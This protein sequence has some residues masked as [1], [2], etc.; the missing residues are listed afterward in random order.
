MRFPLLCALVPV[1]GL[2][3]Q[4]PSGVTVDEAV[5]QALANNA[6]LLAE[7]ANIPI[8][9]ARILTARLRPNPTLSLTGDHLDA[10]GTGFNSDNG[11]GPS[12]IAAGVEF[13][14]ERG[15]KRQSRIRVAEAE[16]SVTELEFLNARRSLVFDVRNAFVDALVA[17]DALALARENSGFFRQIV[18]VNEARVRAGDLAEVE[19]IRSR[20]AA[21]QYETSVRQAELRLRTA[22]VKLQTVMGR[23]RQSPDFAVRGDMDR[24]DVVP[25]AGDV[26]RD[27]LDLRPDLN[28]LRKDV[29]R[30]GAE[31]GLQ[32]A[33]AKQDV[34]LGAEYRRQQWNAHANALTLTFSV[35]LPL[36]DRNQGEIERARQEE[37]QTQLRVR[38]LESSVAGEVE[39]AC[40]QFT[41]ARGLLNTIRGAMLDQARE[42]RNITEF[43]YKRGDASLLALLDAQRAFNDTMQAYIEARAEY[44]RNLYL[45]DFVSGKAVGQ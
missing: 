20:L 9:Q 16:R 24:P 11:G 7:R 37:R 6:G 31:T 43:S 29:A 14:H 15:G 42:V 41:T 38:D 8:A 10:L 12:E 1:A 23:P 25:L 5:A 45:L 27:A 26:R 18:E 13:V 36:F 39:T 33:Q 30:A 34:T 19:L 44:A 35:P 21:L 4:T 32:I 28:A 2:L 22:L 3:A 17:R 40:A